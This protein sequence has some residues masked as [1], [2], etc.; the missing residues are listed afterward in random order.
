MSDRILLLQQYG[1]LVVF[2]IVLVEQIVS[3]PSPR[4]PRTATSSSIAVARTTSRRPTWRCN[5]TGTVIAA[6]N[7]C[8]A[9]WT[10]GTWRIPWQ[11][12]TPPGVRR[13]RTADAL[14]APA[15]FS[16]PFA[17]DSGWT[18]CAGGG[19]CRHQLAEILMAAGRTAGTLIR[20]HS[21]AAFALFP[22]LSGTIG[23]AA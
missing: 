9:A 10:P 18:F 16:S 1:V 21:T 22:L 17:A 2:A 5:C 12:R 23:F 14:F 3:R 20:W 19:R 8:L 11:R 6:P 7:P 4:S 13:P 15:S